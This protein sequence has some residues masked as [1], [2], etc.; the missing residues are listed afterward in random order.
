[1]KSYKELLE[2]DEKTLKK[3]LHY[4]YN[5]SSGVTKFSDLISGFEATWLDQGLYKSDAVINGKLVLQ[6]D[7]QKR[8]PEKKAYKIILKNYRDYQKYKGLK[9]K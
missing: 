8:V 3:L 1:M 5:Q 9:V 6:K 7:N 2:S 4:S